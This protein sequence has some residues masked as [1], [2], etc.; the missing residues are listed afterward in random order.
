ML[1]RR[2]GGRE[3]GIHFIPGHPW[4]C[5]R[6]GGNSRDHLDFIRTSTNISTSSDIS[7]SSLNCLAGMALC[8]A[9]R[10]HQRQFKLLLQHSKRALTFET[11][12][13]K[14]A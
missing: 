13:S 9:F 10:I 14:T 3:G 8:L 2:G 6:S 7:I 12:T 4:N 11:N 5:L 1:G